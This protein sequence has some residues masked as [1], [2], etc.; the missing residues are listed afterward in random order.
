[1]VPHGVRTFVISSL[2]EPTLQICPGRH[3][4]GSKPRV[5]RFSPKAPG[6]TENP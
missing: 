3:E 6:N 5:V 4:F 1:M 2:A